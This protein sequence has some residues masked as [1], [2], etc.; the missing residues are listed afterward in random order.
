MRLRDFMCQYYSLPGI[1]Q[2]F[3]DNM[4]DYWSNFRCR[5]GESVPLF[6]ALVQGEPLNSGLQNLASRN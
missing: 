4:L 2:R 5:Q 6:N 3:R 1:L